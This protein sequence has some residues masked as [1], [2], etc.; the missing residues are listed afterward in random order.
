M[1][2]FSQIDCLIFKYLNIKNVFFNQEDPV[3]KKIKCGDIWL[4]V[5]GVVEKRDFTASASDELGI[6]STDN[7]IFIPARTLIM[8]F[9]NRSLVRADEV[10]TLIASRDNTNQKE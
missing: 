5:I 10:E 7:K 2:L 4:Q 9:K 8:R 6:S 3:G 1:V